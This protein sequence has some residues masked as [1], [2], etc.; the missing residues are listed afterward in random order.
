MFPEVRSA[1]INIVCFLEANRPSCED[2]GIDIRF[3]YSEFGFASPP[4]VSPSPPLGS[5][6]AF[7]ICFSRSTYRIHSIH[8]LN[9]HSS[10]IVHCR[11]SKPKAQPD[12]AHDISGGLVTV[13]CTAEPSLPRRPRSAKFSIDRPKAGDHRPLWWSGHRV[14][15]ESSRTLACG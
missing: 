5:L 6:P 9:S 13:G 7:Y 4:S 11:V 8:Q 1:R 15:V 3:C 10:H 12:P 14:A 2:F